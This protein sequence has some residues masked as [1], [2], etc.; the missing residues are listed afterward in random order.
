MRLFIFFG[1]LLS[2]AAAGDKL[3]LSSEPVKVAP[4]QILQGCSIQGLYLAAWLNHDPAERQRAMLQW[5]D[6]NQCTEQDYANIWNSLSEW[7][8][9]SD[10]PLLR[11]R[12]MQGY[13]KARKK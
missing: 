12:V 11:A 13:E 7:A 2:A 6:D 4:K 5:L 10:G 9:T 1:L 3:I 8:G